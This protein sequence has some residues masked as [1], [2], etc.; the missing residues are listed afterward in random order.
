MI[1]FISTFVAFFPRVDSSCDYDYKEFGLSYNCKKHI[2]ND[3]VNIDMDF[4]LCQRDP[5]K[6]VVQINVYKRAVNRLI[7]CSTS[8]NFSQNIDQLF[9]LHFNFR[10][11]I[12]DGNRVEFEISNS[13]NRSD[14][15]RII[16]PKMSCI[17]IW[18]WYLSQ[19]LTTKILVGIVIIMPF[20]IFFV[21]CYVSSRQRL[22]GSFT[23]APLVMNKIRHPSG[24]Y[25]KTE[26][27]PMM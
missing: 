11:Q 5:T 27:I 26:D 24:R 6:V 7:Y 3:T 23:I 18:H 25:R 4:K 20:F 17:A 19:A 22:Q 21:Y 15:L 2:L 8:S 10:T 14:I 9:T 1:I 12:D 16:S 13:A